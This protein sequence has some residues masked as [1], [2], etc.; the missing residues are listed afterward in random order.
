MLENWIRG[1]H[2]YF[3]V[4]AWASLTPLEHWGSQVERRRRENRGAVG[5]DGWGLG[6][7]YVPSQKIY[8]FFISKCCDMVH[9]GYVVL[10]F[11]CPMDCSCMINLTE[12]PVCARSSAEGKKWN[13][14]QNIGGSSAQDDPCKSNIGRSRPLRSM[15]LWVIGQTSRWQHGWWPNSR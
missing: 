14:C 15:G 5:G 12:L 1:N 10:R 7:A 2:C 6:M 11:M 9:Y 8:D 4:M 13:T 3:A